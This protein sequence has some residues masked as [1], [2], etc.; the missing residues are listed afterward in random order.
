MSK[1][2]VHERDGVRYV[3]GTEEIQGKQVPCEMEIIHKC[4]CGFE[5]P[6]VLTPLE[7]KALVK[8]CPECR[9]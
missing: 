9:K 6:D 8:E 7:V 2:K 5:W 3:M 4:V 1:Q